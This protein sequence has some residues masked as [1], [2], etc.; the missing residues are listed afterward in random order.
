M[1]IQWKNVFL[2]IFFKEMIEI[3]TLSDVKMHEK[4]GKVKVLT[5]GKQFTIIYQ[6][7]SISS[8]WNE[9]FSCF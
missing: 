3:T 1:V 8:R 4:D 5:I 6:N 2:G 7:L 9:I